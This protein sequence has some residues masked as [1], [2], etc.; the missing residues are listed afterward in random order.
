MKTLAVRRSGITVLAG[1]VAAAFFAVAGP[2]QHASAAAT[3]S[4][5]PQPAAAAADWLAAQLRDGLI[6]DDRSGFDNYGLTVEVAYALRAVGGHDAEIGEISS[7]LQAAAEQYVGPAPETSAASTGKLLSFASDTGADPRSFGGVDLVA[8]LEAATTDTG[9]ATGR[10]VDQ[11]QQADSANTFGQAWAVRGLLNA[12]SAEGPAALG[13]LLKQQCAAGF[14][15]LYFPQDQSVDQS[16]DRAS[17]AEP[18]PA[19]DTAALVVVLLDDKRGVSAE[20][21]AA[22][23]RA[24]AWIKSQQAADGSFDGGTALEGPNAS[25]TGLAGWALRLTGAS[26]AA[27]KAA[28]WLRRHQVSGNACDG[29]ARS[30]VGAVAYDTTA[31]FDAR[32]FGI[33]TANGAQWRT[34]AAQATPALVAAP[35]A[36]SALRATA[37]TFARAPSSVWVT[38]SGLAPGARGCVNLVG[39]NVWVI[40]EIKPSLAFGL[41][42]GT[43]THTATLT[44]FAGATTTRRITALAPKRLP[45]S[46]RETRLRAGRTQYIRISGLHPGEKVSVHYGGVVV[47]RGVARSNGAFL[48][49]FPVGS[50]KG[51]KRVYV[52]GQFPTRRNSAPFTLV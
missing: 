11:G 10:I 43:K 2:G 33:T 25:S 40:G 22:L 30:E 16:C 18:V 7:A 35:A 42:D 9:P 31:Y 37:P 5:D 1:A 47:R 28:V 51:D 19:V 39:R 21:D 20:L 12:G 13:Y 24:I 8:R 15:R 36:S 38:V 34:V 23:D 44:G 14:F 3:A 41:P 32:K 26:A 4:T 17:P 52:R 45:V 6:H 49:S 48:T 46:I 29:L 50:S 27:E